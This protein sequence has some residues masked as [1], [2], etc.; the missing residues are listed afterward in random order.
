MIFKAYAKINLALN[1]N[2]R[3]KDGY[4]DVD[5]VLLPIDLYDSI[6]ITPL[7]PGLNTIVTT[8]NPE[9]N[10]EPTNLVQ[11]AVKVTREIFN[12]TQ[13]FHIHVYKKIPLAAGLGGGTSDGVVTFLALCS[14]L[15]LRPTA[16]DL[17]IITQRLGADTTFFFLTK[18]ARAEV[19]GDK[20][21]Q[22]D[23]ADKYNILLIRPKEGLSSQE[24]FEKSDEY[25]DL[26]QANIDE[27]LQGLHD[28][29]F[30]LIKKNCINALEKPAIALL[31]EIGNLKKILIERF[32][33]EAVSMTGSGST[34]FA[35]SKKKR[36]IDKAYKI[37]KREG[38]SV[39]RTV[40]LFNE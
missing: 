14:I 19:I 24:V 36:K 9:L 6:E 8:D 3:R 27:L 38:Y 5:S 7:P 23:V 4:H 18:P 25:P 39:Y 40:T 11:T 31:P 15:K 13:N 34:V 17:E 22:I 2:G 29:N 30:D 10:H 28:G 12:F 35:L 26:E 16:Q 37:L 32:G 33:F 21:T 1:V 20:I